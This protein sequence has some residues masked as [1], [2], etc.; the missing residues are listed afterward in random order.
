[1]RDANAVDRPFSLRDQT[2]LV[3]GAASGLGL[4]VAR[5]ALVRGASVVAWDNNG[6]KLQSAIDE[7]GTVGDVVGRV[8]DVCDA[9]Q[10]TAE[11]EALGASRAVDALVNSAGL[12]SRRL[13]AIDT[14]L[15]TWRRYVDTN[16]TGCRTMCVA[17]GAGMVQRGRGSI[18]NFSS[19]SGVDPGSGI[20]PYAM[21]KRAIIELTRLLA[22][23]WA[24]AGVRVNALAP[25]PVHT[26]GT[27]VALKDLH[28]RDEWTG[29]V[30]MNRLGTPADIAGMAVFLMSEASSWTTGQTF[31][32]DGGWLLAPQRGDA[33]A[34]APGRSA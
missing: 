8:V 15:S 12:T 24:G 17:V 18:I 7:L 22:S 19:V 31:F 33:P 9:A 5:Q 3:T 2:I 4:E 23:E 13:A 25:G 21:S 14:P 34:P 30:A 20:A 6:A 28:V 32:V 16:L 11:V 10:V 27:Q 29:A 26:E 1:M